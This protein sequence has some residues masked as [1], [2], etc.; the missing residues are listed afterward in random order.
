MDDEERSWR[1]WLKLVEGW[2]CTAQD[3]LPASSAINV[4][5][6]RNA[7]PTPADE[8]EREWIWY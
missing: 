1:D 7:T 5:P 2:A 3:R 4:N 6:A 8:L